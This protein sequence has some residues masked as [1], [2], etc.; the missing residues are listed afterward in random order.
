MSDYTLDGVDMYDIK[1]RKYGESIVIDID[2]PWREMSSSSPTIFVFILAYFF[3]RRFN[4]CA[5]LIG[6]AIGCDCARTPDHLYKWCSR[7]V[8]IDSKVKHQR[9]ISR[10]LQ[11]NTSFR[12]KQEKDVT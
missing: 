5:S 4:N 6:R 2:R 1:Y 9:E 7:Q 11:E 10:R 8:V 12:R 3:P